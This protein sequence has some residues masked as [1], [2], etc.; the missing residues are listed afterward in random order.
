MVI[1]NKIIFQDAGE[2]VILY[3]RTAAFHAPSGLKFRT[4][5]DSPPGNGMEVIVQFYH[6][7]HFQVIPGQFTIGKR[8]Y[9]SGPLQIDNEVGSDDDVASNSQKALIRIKKIFPER[10]VLKSPGRHKLNQG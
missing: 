9:F 5:H 3:L 10:M 4:P 1:V 8:I 6:L 7:L 2:G